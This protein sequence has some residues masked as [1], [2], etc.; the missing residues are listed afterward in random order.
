MGRATRDGY[1]PRRCPVRP[2][3]QGG[4]KFVRASFGRGSAAGGAAA[5][6]RDVGGRWRAR[7]REERGGRPGLFSCTADLPSDRHDR[8]AK[9]AKQAKGSQGEPRGTG[10]EPRRPSLAGWNCSNSRAVRC[11]ATG[12]G[13][14]V[15]RGRRREKGGLGR[16]PSVRIGLKRQRQRRPR[17]E[18]SGKTAP[19][20]GWWF[21]SRTR[22]ERADRGGG[23]AVESGKGDGHG[24]AWPRELARRA[25]AVAP[26][27][28]LCRESCRVFGEAGQPTGDVLFA[29]WWV[30]VD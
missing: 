10:G 1:M 4:P 7:G 3:R 15:G 26:F 27:V 30:S 6:G 16:G 22:G 14:P 9:E 18:G 5:G 28:V 2:V 29:A 20:D 25:H 17:R 11:A 8:W 19:S 21:V 12:V 24:P 13:L 23:R